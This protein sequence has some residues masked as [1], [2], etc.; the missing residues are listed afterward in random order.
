MLNVQGRWNLDEN[1]G[2]ACS[3][4]T[5]ETSHNIKKYD[6]WADWNPWLQCFENL[7][8]KI[9]YL[10]YTTW[11]SKSLHCKTFYNTTDLTFHSNK[12]ISLHIKAQNIIT[13]ICWMYKDAEPF[14][15]TKALRVPLQH[16]EPVTT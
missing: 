15:K 13:Q 6:I 8:L 3:Y 2:A 4:A 10:L 9:H 11:Q 7:K 14:M 5:C 16:V 1:V 12:I